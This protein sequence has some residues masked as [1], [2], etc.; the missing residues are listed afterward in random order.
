MLLLTTKQM[1]NT[2]KQE[3]VLLNLD[4]QR[5]K[6]IQEYKRFYQM[7]L[8]EDNTELG[9]NLIKTKIEDL[10]NEEKEILKRCKVE[11]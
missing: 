7:K 10:E 6:E 4:E 9:V 11:L 1:P 8:D 3:L 2:R 5:L